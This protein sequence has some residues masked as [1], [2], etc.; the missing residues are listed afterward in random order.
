MSWGE[1]NE[2][3]RQEDCSMQPP[4]VRKR[5][6]PKAESAA[7]QRRRE[8]FEDLDESSPTYRLAGYGFKIT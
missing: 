8:E 5:K 3:E 6:P 7:S 2:R 1:R 4:G